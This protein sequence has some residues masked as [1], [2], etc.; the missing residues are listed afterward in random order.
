[1]RVSIAALRG[2][3]LHLC[4]GASS[5]V[6]SRR[7]VLDCAP[8]PLTPSLRHASDQVFVRMQMLF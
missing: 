7:P 8:P 6:A 3:R 2:G 4:R 5:T 1:M